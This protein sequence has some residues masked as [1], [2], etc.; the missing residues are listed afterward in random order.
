M[1]VHEHNERETREKNALYRIGRVTK[2]QR[3]KA[4]RIHGTKQYRVKERQIIE[5]PD[6]QALSDQLL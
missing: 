3:R 1:C 5:I 4:E 6:S 2:T